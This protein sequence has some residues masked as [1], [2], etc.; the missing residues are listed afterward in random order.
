MTPKEVGVPIEV[1]VGLEVVV[2]LVLAI[3]GKV[4]VAPY[5]GDG[6]VWEANGINTIVNVGGGCGS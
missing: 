4:V 6:C 2:V 1:E 3:G 5:W